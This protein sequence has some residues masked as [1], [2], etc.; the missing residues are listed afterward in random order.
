[1]DREEARSR[2]GDEAVRPRAAHDPRRGAA[3]L[4]MRLAIN[5]GLSLGMLALCMWLV[6]PD[7]GERVE[8]HAVIGG[9]RWADFAPYLAGWVALQIAVHLCRSLRCNH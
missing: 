1:M 3:G 7:A 9:M 5:L 6:W 2:R 8:L 4:T